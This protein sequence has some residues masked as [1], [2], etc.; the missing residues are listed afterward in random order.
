MYSLV[1][2]LWLVIATPALH[3]NEALNSRLDILASDSNEESDPEA[4]ILH[5]SAHV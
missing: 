3:R 5:W 2:A 1:I 4:L